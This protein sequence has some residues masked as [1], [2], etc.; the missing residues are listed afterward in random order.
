MAAIVSAVVALLAMALV[1]R[2]PPLVQANDDAD[3]K[4][5]RAAH[6]PHGKRYYNDF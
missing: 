6:L 5:S 2:Q 1:S 3:M 4:S